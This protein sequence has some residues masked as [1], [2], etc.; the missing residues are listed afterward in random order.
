MRL[1]DLMRAGL[2]TPTPFL[3]QIFVHKPDT[4]TGFFVDFLEDAHDFFLLGAVGEDFCCMGQ[5]ADGYRCYAAV[6][7]VGCDAA[8]HL[9]V[10]SLHV[11]HLCA[12]G[13]RVVWMNLREEELSSMVEH[14]RNDGAAFDE[15]NFR[16]G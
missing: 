5:R 16:E 9:A 15:P 2:L 1:C 8:D 4:P 13:G 3:L 12:V 14:P 7:D 6:F 10:A 11:G